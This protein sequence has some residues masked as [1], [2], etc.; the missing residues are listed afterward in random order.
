MLTSYEDFTINWAND[1]GCEQEQTRVALVC[2]KVRE[3]RL[4]HMF[5]LGAVDTGWAFVVS[6]GRLLQRPPS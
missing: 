6:L 1:D 2:F 5:G 3:D 4:F